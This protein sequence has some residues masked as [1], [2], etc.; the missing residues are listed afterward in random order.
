MAAVDLLGDANHRLIRA[1]RCKGKAS[2]NDTANRETN[3]MNKLLPVG[4]TAPNFTLPSSASGAAGQDGQAISLHDFKG[5]N[6]ILAFYPA[7]WSA[8]CGD[9]LALFNEV[10]PLF[11]KY[12]ADLLGISVDNAFCHAAFK[13][14]RGFRM[15]LLADFEPKGA[16][17][18]QY[19]V[20]DDKDGFSKR[21]LFVIDAQ[22]IV[23]YSFISPMDVN[24]G[25]NE[26]LKTLKEI[27]ANGGK[28]Q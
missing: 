14:D 27:K 28:S 12:N 16:V 25:A 13:D 6:V 23:R 5:R 24:P 2:F 26:L 4:A 9:E 8:V 20:Y 21:A 11:Q 18:R 3:T 17:S 15:S 19:G 1:L 10:L 22:G 7:D